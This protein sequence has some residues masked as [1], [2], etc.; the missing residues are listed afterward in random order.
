MINFRSTSNSKTYRKIFNTNKSKN[1]A[2]NWKKKSLLKKGL[3]MMEK[4]NI[5]IRFQ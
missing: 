4:F 1:L 5:Y 3:V 2:I